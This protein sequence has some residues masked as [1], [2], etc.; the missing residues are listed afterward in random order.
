L[1]VFATMAAAAVALLMFPAAGAA[2]LAVAIVVISLV[3]SPLILLDPIALR[4]LRVTSRTDYARIRLRMSA[5]WAASSVASGALYQAV[6]MR[7][8]PFVYAPLAAVV[9][10]WVWRA[11]KPEPPA[12]RAT[13]D[14]SVRAPLHVRRIPVPMDS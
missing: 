3:R 7:L 5:G 6:S 13:Q 11:I 10:L 1:V 2:T 14:P 12:A 4:K 8:I 9:G